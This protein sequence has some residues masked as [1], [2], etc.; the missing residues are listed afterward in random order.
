MGMWKCEKL[1]GTWN[2]PIIWVL[3]KNLHFFSKLLHSLSLLQKF[4]AVN[5]L[6]KIP[7][8]LPHLSPLFIPCFLVLNNR[9]P[10]FL[11]RF[12]DIFYISKFYFQVHQTDAGPILQ[13][14]ICHYLRPS[15]YANHW[16]SVYRGWLRHVW[17]SRRYR[18]VHSFP[19]LMTTISQESQASWTKV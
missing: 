8:F 9:K 7:Y 12:S 16:C 1:F 2:R 3:F 5:I 17:R 18:Y 14:G 13:R 15:I 6:A 19:F 10:L 4:S 11:H